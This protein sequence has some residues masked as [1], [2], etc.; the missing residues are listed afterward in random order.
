MSSQPSPR[1]RKTRPTTVRRAPCSKKSSEGC[2]NRSD[3]IALV[4]FVGCFRWPDRLCHRRVQARARTIRRSPCRRRYK[5]S[6]HMGKH[7]VEFRMDWRRPR[8]DACP[9]KVGR[10]GARRRASSPWSAGEALDRTERRVKSSPPAS[11]RGMK[12]SAASFA[13]RSGLAGKNGLPRLK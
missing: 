10:A 7:N 3:Y 6:C 13:W 4:I 11:L 8:Q 5:R 12:T 9:T 1:Q 2:M